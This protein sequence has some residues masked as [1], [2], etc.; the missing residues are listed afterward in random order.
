MSISVDISHAMAGFHLSAKFHADQGVTAIFG[1]SGSGKTTLINAIAGLLRPDQ[2]RIEINDRPVFDS[3]KGTHLATHKRRV[4]YVFQDARLFPHLSVVKNLR[5]GQRFHRRATVAENDVVDMLGIGDLLDRH[6]GA[7]SG[8]EKQRVAIGRALLSAPD[9]LLMDEPL[10]ALDAARKDEILPYLERLRDHANLPIL[11]VSHSVAEVARLANTLVLLKDGIAQRSGPVSQLLSDPDL[12]PLFGLREAG[13]ILPV[14]VLRHHADGL[15]ELRSSGGT[16]LLPRVS[17]PQGANLRI[18]I[19]ANEVMLS[20]ERPAAISALNV[21]PVEVETLRIGS[22]PGALVR[23]KSGQDRLLARL[24]RR[25]AQGL[26]LHP[27]TRCY[28]IIKSVSVAQGDVG[29]TAIR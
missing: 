18:R 9:L 24:T 27:G 4:G 13:A 10:A 23:L 26:D 2:G 1:H 20:L 17:A 11:Y 3:A 21:L 15:T 19:H 28:A 16:F 12:A 14:T 7:L 22:G 5:Y 29:G 6:P 8:G 25:S